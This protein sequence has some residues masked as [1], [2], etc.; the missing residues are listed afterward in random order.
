MRTQA[1]NRV[2]SQVGRFHSR[3]FF[4]CGALLFSVLSSIFFFGADPSA[5]EAA[6]DDLVFGP[7]TRVT[8]EPGYRYSLSA[9][10][11]MAVWEEDDFV[12]LK[13]FT[14][15]A[16]TQ[17]IAGDAYHPATLPDINGN[18]I[19]WQQDGKVCWQILGG[20]SSCID[21][22]FYANENSIP[23]VSA[24][25]IVWGDYRNGDADI[26]LYDVNSGKEQA[27]Y[28][29]PGDQ[30]VP[31]MDGN[32]VVWEDY[33]NGTSDI[34][35]YNLASGQTMQI[36]DDSNLDFDP[37]V[38]GDWVAYY[39]NTGVNI[40]VVWL[41]NL[42]SGQ[43]Q[44]LDGADSMSWGPPQFENN[45]VIWNRWDR[46]TQGAK[47][48]L[49]LRDLVNRKTY[50]VTDGSS[51]ATHPVLSSGRI[52]WFDDRNRELGQTEDVYYMT[53]DNAQM[54][55]DRFRRNSNL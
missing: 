33:Q 55:A 10:G 41:Y 44:L 13:N 4:I 23:S 51:F 3:S 26:Y 30:T 52:V 32:W 39:E 9:S 50:T 2:A 49:Y 46:H 5:A 21:S 27:I 19:T 43:R 18:L 48:Q 45:M 40:N 47:S 8:T 16:P 38:G 53:V 14:N 6:G 35:A 15:D 22:S 24:G 31:R 7:D 20:S 36:S 29:G 1:I 25:R 34:M 11:D 28:V 17:I 12:Y 42:Y 37:S 54:L